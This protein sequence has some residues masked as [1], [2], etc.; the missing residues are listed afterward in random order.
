MSLHRAASLRHSGEP[1]RPSGA[2]DS[3]T[4]WAAT[5]STMATTLRYCGVT[6]PTSPLTAYSAPSRTLIPLQ[7]GQ[8]QA[9]ED[10]RTWDEE[11]ARTYTE[12]VWAGARWGRRSKHAAR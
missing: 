1:Y 5:S 2:D 7:A 6:S 4:A 3:L 10:T 9:F 8:I 11:A 12:T